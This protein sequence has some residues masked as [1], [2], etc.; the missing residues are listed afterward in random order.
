MTNQTSASIQPKTDKKLKNV[1]YCKRKRGLVKKAM[2]LSTL[3]QQ[4]ICV[5]IY[6]R[7]KNKIVHFSSDGF[8]LN[9]ANAL[10]KEHV[11]TKNKKFENWTCKDYDYI[12]RGQ[13]VTG[14]YRN[15]MKLDSDDDLA[16][17]ETTPEKPE[18]STLKKRDEKLDEKLTIPKYFKL[19]LSEPLKLD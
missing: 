15:P 18:L 19:D 4:E 5:V 6:D 16:A 10:V 11:K 14:K 2:E 17:V 7:N 8:S 3:C 1:T 9:E 13:S 12:K